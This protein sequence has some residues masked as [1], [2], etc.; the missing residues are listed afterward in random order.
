M[1]AD[2]F[3]HGPSMSTADRAAWHD[4]TRDRP[5]VMLIT[6]SLEPS[7]VG[8][9]M[10]TLAAALEHHVDVRLVFADAP[11]AA[12]WAERARTQ[13]L[14]AALAPA[15]ALVEGEAPLTAVFERQRPDV[16]HVHA[17]IGWEGQTIVEAARRW[18]A[19]AIVRTEH[20]PYLL[21]GQGNAALEAAYA[22]TVGLA[23]RV[24]C[25][26]EAARRTYRGSRADIARF[27][28]VRNGI[29]PKP[30]M[31]G[32]DEVRGS[33]GI[34]SAPL[35][36]TVARFTEQKSHVT[37]LDALPRLL[38]ARPDAQLAWVGSGPLEQALRDRARATG[39]DDHVL[40]LGRRNDVPDLMGAADV[41][42][43][44]SRFEGHPLVALEAMAAGLPV[45]A[46]RS[47]GIT[48][49]VR[50][51][52]TGL[53]FPFGSAAMLARTLAR[54]LDD[55]DLA[56]RLGAAGRAAVHDCFSAERMAFETLAVYRS[57]LARSPDHAMAPVGQVPVSGV[58][59]CEARGAVQ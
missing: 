29:S 32:R 14:D 8:E 22:R 36:L 2:C 4:D 52:V 7:G 24:I 56:A 49:A 31:R 48:E 54:A 12:G 21:R 17:G 44:P 13:G 45:V 46:A 10:L 58:R 38:A 50:H 34:G 33:L 40:F 53:L 55:P 43:L 28:V 39:V 35:I 1:A 20:L 5:R 9:H 23:D 41:F 25:V 15:A 19:R 3:P 51:D 18:G 59:S 11:D 26:C 37:L 47:M 6:D 57:V 16:V 30:P 42:C 27:C